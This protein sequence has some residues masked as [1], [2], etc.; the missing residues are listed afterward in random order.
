MIIPSNLYLDKEQ[1]VSFEAF[2]ERNKN[3]IKAIIVLLDIRPFKSNFEFNDYYEYFSHIAIKYKLITIGIFNEMVS[4]QYKDSLKEAVLAFDN[5]FYNV[6]K[7]GIRVIIRPYTHYN[8]NFYRYKDL[9]IFTSDETLYTHFSRITNNNLFFSHLDYLE[10]GISKDEVKIEKQKSKFSKRLS[11]AHPDSTTE[12]TLFYKSFVNTDAKLIDEIDDI[13]FGSEFIYDD[14]IKVV[15]YGNVMGVN[16]SNEQIDYLFKIQEEHGISIS[17]TLNSMEP[18]MDLVYDKDVLNKFILWLDKFYQRGLR[19]VTI[20]HIHLMKL[21]I[22][23][24]QFPLMK[25]KNTVNH[26]VSDAQMFTNFSYIGYDYIQLD[27]SLN[28][29]LDELKKI[30]KLS[31]KLNKKTYMLI[32]EFCMYSCPYKHEHDT[33]NNKLQSA[34][35]Y[36]H[37][38]IKLSSISCDNWRFSKYSQMPRIGVDV[39]LKDEKALE[40]YFDL[41][42][43]FK[44][45]GRLANLDNL[46]ITEKTCL[47]INAAKSLESLTDLNALSQRLRVEFTSYY[48]TPK[49]DSLY[50]TKEGKKLLDKLKT[51]KNQCYDCHLCEKVFGCDS[52]DSLLELK[53]F[54]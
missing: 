1:R 36:F 15:K 2:C 16:A 5:D 48:K 35:S 49:I 54:K 7:R 17:L 3:D 12:G 19:V 25:F 40:E 42:D 30:K 34:H 39:M 21:G 51:C 13:Y 53:K 9:K 52:F 24:E 50:K 20:S 4:I 22:L 23:K 18:P 26:K 33:V 14:G 27:R 46:E 44:F 31:L 38:D 6:Y 41:V 29:N 8:F 10:N 43:V 11:I 32:S 28:R 47:S 37:G 45:S